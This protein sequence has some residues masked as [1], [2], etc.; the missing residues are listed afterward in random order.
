MSSQNATCYVMTPGSAQQEPSSWLS[1]A[2]QKTS[3]SAF[4]DIPY[5]VSDDQQ[6]ISYHFP[7]A[8]PQRVSETERKTTHGVRGIMSAK[9]RVRESGMIKIWVKWSELLRHT[10]SYHIFA[11]CCHCSW[12]TLLRR[13]LAWV[14]RSELCVCEKSV[15]YLWRLHL[16]RE[17]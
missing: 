7:W 11:F 2:H 16:V 13:V 4:F 10:D 12:I 5:H 8:L 14:R 17:S 6:T 1:Q 3:F 15:Y 9:W